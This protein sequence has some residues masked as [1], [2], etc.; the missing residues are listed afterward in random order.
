MANIK[1]SELTVFTAPDAA[2]LVPL[3]LIPIN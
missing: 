3:T 1:I 2:D